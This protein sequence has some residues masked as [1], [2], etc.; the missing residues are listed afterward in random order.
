MALARAE[1]AAFLLFLNAQ[2]VQSQMQMSQDVVLPHGNHTFELKH[3]N[4]QRSYIAHMPPAADWMQPLPVVLN[5]HGGG[6][7][8]AQ[9]QKSIKMDAVADR[10]GFIAVYPNGTGRFR[11]RLLTWNAGSCCGQ[12][13]KDNVDDVGFVLHLLDDLGTRTAIDRERI[14]AAGHSNGA[15]LA[16]RLAAE[17]TDHFSAIAAVSGGMVVK[18]FA[19][20]NPIPILHIH[21]VD[22]PRALYDG[23]LGPPFPLT[24]YRVQHPAVEDVLATWL[25]FNG[26]TAEP[27]TVEVRHGIRRRDRGHSAI[28]LVYRA[29]ETGAEVVFWQLHGPGH[30]WP[31]IEKARFERIVGPA[32]TVIDANEEIWAFFKRHKKR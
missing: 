1:V 20:A 4:Q 22:D 6:G 24:R 21:S 31:G 30:G 18:N 25:A 27:D 29:G 10:E 16:Y 13:Q 28:K 11:K 15:M 19:P 9:L 23:G 17:A 7:N 8:A 3:D 32:T 12:A 26:C 14:Y 5:F 2:S